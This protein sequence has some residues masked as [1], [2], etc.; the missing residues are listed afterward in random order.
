MSVAP[1][2]A[3]LDALRDGDLDLAVCVEPPEPR[4]GIVTEF[5]LDEP[6]VVIAPRGMRTDDPRDWGPWA[7]FP[8]GSHTRSL[9][10]ERLHELGAPLVIA[11]ESH[12]PTVLVQL[13]RLGLGWTVL[14]VRDPPPDVELGPVLVRRRLVLARRRAAFADPAVDEM[15]DRLRTGSVRGTPN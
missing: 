1:S 7:T 11:A 8:I 5:L 4:D 15:A 3:L 10:V 6:L 12:Q 13:A 9:I 14:P 2:A